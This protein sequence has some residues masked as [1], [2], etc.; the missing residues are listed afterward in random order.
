MRRTI[1]GALVAAF[2]VA[3][4]V[5]TEAGTAQKGAANAEWRHYGGDARGTKY[6]P[7]DQINASNVKDLQIVWRWKTSNLG[8]P[9]ENNW[10]VTPLA[11]GGTLYFTAGPGRSAVAL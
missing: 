11:I 3:I 6:S 10:E 9:T 1:S 5:F 4:L 7:L 2:A 8:L